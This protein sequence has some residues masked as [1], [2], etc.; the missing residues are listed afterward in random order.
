[1]L[2]LLASSEKP[3]DKLLILAHATCLR[4]LYINAFGE[5]WALPR[6]GYEI[7]VNRLQSTNVDRAYT[8]TLGRKAHHIII[9][10]LF[11]N[12]EK[13][14]FFPKLVFQYEMIDDEIHNS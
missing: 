12:T 5:F 3:N 11:A 14:S 7:I 2:R 4:M 6:D 10:S 1:M 8:K 9:N 13:Y